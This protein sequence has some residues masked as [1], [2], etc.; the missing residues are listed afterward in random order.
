[1][2]PVLFRIP[3]FSGVTIYSY[4]V[5]VAL[6]FVVA[7]IWVSYES[8]RLGEDSAKAMDLVFYVIVAGIVGS[9][10]LHVAIAERERFFANPL[11]IFRIWEGGLV[12]YGGLVTSLVV[13]AWYVRRHAMSFFT[14][15]DI[16]AP[17]ISIGHAIGRI[18]CFLVGCCYGRP[19]D[20]PAWYSIVFPLK[21]KTFAPTGIPLYP[22]QL[23]EVAGELLIFSFLMLLRHH[24]RFKGQII[25]SYIMLYAI[26]RFINE[27]FRGDL[28]RGFVIDP[29][30]STSQFISIILFVVGAVVYM[31]FKKHFQKE[32]GG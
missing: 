19:V 22:T 18:G 12:F 24:Q 25:T 17:A 7:I 8:K 10:V 16:F 30:L 31:R 29:W 23:M 5:M 11:M 3:I 32:T 26:L 13:A 15:A 21:Q 20:H 1:M 2:H 6:G 28:E 14:T 27:Y 9:R 4:G